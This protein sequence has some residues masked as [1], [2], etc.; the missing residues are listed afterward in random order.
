MEKA[1]KSNY[2]LGHDSLAIANYFINLSKGKGL[3]LVKLIKLSYIAH[4][5]KLG[6]DG[7]PLA[8]EYV[9]AWKFGP[10]FSRIYYE[11]KHQG[12][13]IKQPAKDIFQ[14]CKTI[15]SD[16]NSREQKLM[17]KVFKVYGKKTAAYLIAITHKK[18]SPWYKAWH[19]DK[20]SEVLNFQIK[21]DDIKKYYTKQI[22]E[23]RAG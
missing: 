19:E 17:E 9:E 6:F 22:K 13:N 4:G 12:I 5:F 20:G 18:D 2:E 10:V 11:F 14:D 23:S 16:F 3:S 7:Y 8:N 15:S 1:K 21:N